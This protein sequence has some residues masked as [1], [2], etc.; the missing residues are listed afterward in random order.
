MESKKRQRNEDSDEEDEDFEK[1]IEVEEP[2][3]IDQPFISKPEA[4]KIKTSRE[5]PYLSTVNREVLDFDF[6]R[7]CRY[8]YLF[9]CFF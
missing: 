6:E 8:C 4:T 7:L 1:Q 5:C 2:D 3:T 9:F